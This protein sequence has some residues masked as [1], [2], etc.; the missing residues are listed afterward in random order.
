MSGSDCSDVSPPLSADEVRPILMPEFLSI[1]TFCTIG[2]LSRRN[3]QTVHEL[4]MASVRWAA[5]AGE[6][7]AMSEPIYDKDYV[8]RIGRHKVSIEEHKL[9]LAE[10]ANKLSQP[11]IFRQE[12]VLSETDEVVAEKQRRHARKEFYSKIIKGGLVVGAVGL[13]TMLVLGARCLHKEDYSTCG[14]RDGALAC[15]IIPAVVFGSIILYPVVA[16]GVWL[17]GKA[18]R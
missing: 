13:T 12:V 3:I 1:R 14:S 8:C 17:C 15:V 18:Y 6:S 9:T 10:L 11:D 5:S 16:C 2:S 4:I 7:W